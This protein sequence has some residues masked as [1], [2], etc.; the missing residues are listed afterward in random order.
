MSMFSKEDLINRVG[1]IKVLPFVARKVL[2]TL[3][4]ESCTIDDLSNIIEKDQAIA[5]RVLKISNSA[6]YGLRHEVTSLHQAIL[7]LG[8]KTIRSLVLSVSTRGLYKSF[9]MKEKILWDHSVGAAIAAKMI[10]AGFGSEVGEVSFIGGLMHDFGKVVMNNET[11][12]VFGEV[13]MKIYNED[14]ESIAAE[15]EIYGFNHTEIGARVIEK[16]GFAPLLVSILENH[17]LNNL[18][19]QDIKDEAVA[20]SIAIVNLADNVCKVLG[21]GYRSPNEA[22]KLHELP[23]AVFLNIEKNK[24]ALLTGNIQETYDREKSVFE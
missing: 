14:I 16:W 4:D 3:K 17:H 24:L 10:S 20:K 15:E 12:D 2:E 13:I 18:K 6:M 9:G 23:P 11:P 19:L 8:F 22:I 21:I 7:V 1:D 5:A